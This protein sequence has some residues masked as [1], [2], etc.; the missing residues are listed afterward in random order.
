[1][2]E[3]SCGGSDVSQ[4]QMSL[5]SGGKRCRCCGEVSSYQMKEMKGHVVDTSSCTT[6]PDTY[7]VTVCSL[8]ITVL[9]SN[10]FLDLS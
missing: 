6:S 3:K 10:L 9:D 4:Y 5:L 7:R 1:M 2:M 8:A